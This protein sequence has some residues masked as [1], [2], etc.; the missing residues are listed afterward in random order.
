MTKEHVLNCS[1]LFT[2]NHAYYPVKTTL[3]LRP[4]FSLS[5]TMKLHM[6]CT[7][8]GS[9]VHTL[10]DLRAVSRTLWPSQ[11]AHTGNCLRSSYHIT[12][13]HQEQ[14]RR[15]CRA[16]VVTKAGVAAASGQTLASQALSHLEPQ[17]AFI[18]HTLCC[19][20]LLPILGGWLFATALS[21]VASRARQVGVVP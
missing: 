2:G 3:C 6:C 19:G 1:T 5:S 12:H 7:G 17:L 8:A 20:M 11:Q 21:A 4:R 9:H 15:Q 10:P 16:Q 13:K 18:A 14:Q